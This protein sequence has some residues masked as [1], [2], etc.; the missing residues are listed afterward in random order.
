MWNATGR[1]RRLGHCCGRWGWHVSALGQLH[2]PQQ[3]PNLWNT[4]PIYGI[5]RYTCSWWQKL[6]LAVTWIS[7]RRCCSRCLAR[8]PS[9]GQER[10][11]AL[12][13]QPS[14]P[15]PPGSRGTRSGQQTV[16]GRWGWC[17]R[18]KC[19]AEVAAL[20]IPSGAWTCNR[21]QKMLTKLW[22]IPPKCD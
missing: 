22:Q 4:G 20:T 12:W 19:W 5:R 2:L 1:F 16:P 13:G 3:W 9:P 18:W 15:A 21:K 7:C 14:W 10:C 6:R 11:L 17:K 8:T